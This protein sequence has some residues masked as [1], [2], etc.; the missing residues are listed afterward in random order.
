MRFLIGLL[1]ISFS[2]KAQDSSH[3]QIKER[4]KILFSPINLINI[5]GPSFQLAYERDLS[6]KYSAQIELG[7][8]LPKSLIGYAANFIFDGANWHQFF[9]YTINGEVKYYLKRRVA[10]FYNK[11]RNSSVTNYIA[12]NVFHNYLECHCSDYFTSLESTFINSE[13]NIVE[14][15]YIDDYELKKTITGLNVKWG[16]TK[17]TTTGFYMNLYLGLGI[18]YRNALHNN[19]ENYNDPMYSNFSLP[20]RSLL[21]RSGKGIIA[22]FPVNFKIGY[23]F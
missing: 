2:L 13:G 17:I 21:N 12:L 23:S 18:A 3:F 5:H 20:N 16:L 4:N 11:T 7:Y 15:S 14:V 8:I 10:R 19:R 22:T 1:F 9:G 6:P